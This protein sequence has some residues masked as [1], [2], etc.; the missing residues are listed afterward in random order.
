MCYSASECADRLVRNAISPFPPVTVTIYIYSAGDC[1]DVH[2]DNLLPPAEHRLIRPLDPIHVADI[3]KGLKSNPQ[4]Y[5]ILAGVLVE[6]ELNDLTDSGKTRVEV[7]GGNHTRAA[8]QALV[9][10]G[11]LQCETLKVKVYTGLTTAEALQVGYR[12]NV[13][14]ASSKDMQF[15]DTVRVIH[16]QLNSRSGQEKRR[17]K[18][19][20]AMIFGYEVRLEHG[21]LGLEAKPNPTLLV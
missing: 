15:M 12:H 18:A 1:V 4:Q 16:K 14:A 7:I 10:D 3:V 8:F 2:I 5:C 6:G 9:A 17:R 13:V 11:T 19:D 21:I 20:L